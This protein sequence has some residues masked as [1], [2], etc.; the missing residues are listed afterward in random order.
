MDQSGFGVDP[1]GRIAGKP[2]TG[3]NPPKVLVITWLL[4]MWKSQPRTD[5]TVAAN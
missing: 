1:A 4:T 3:S 2:E 5:G